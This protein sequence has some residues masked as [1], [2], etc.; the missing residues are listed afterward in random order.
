MLQLRAVIPDCPRIGFSFDVQRNEIHWA[1]TVQG[2]PS[3]H[4]LQILR[5]QLL[6]KAFHAAA[7]QLEHALVLAGA[8]GGEHFLIIIVDPVHI[9][10]EAPALLQKAHRVL[11]HRQS[12]QSQKVHL[13][14][15]QLFQRRHRKLSRQ[16]SVGRPGERHILHDRKLADHHA[17]RVHRRVSGQSF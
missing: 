1:R 15:P 10:M 9:Q 4:V 3:N 6:H 16:L 8:D 5:F 17:R 12:P 11:N 13:E 7:F 2:N 14:K